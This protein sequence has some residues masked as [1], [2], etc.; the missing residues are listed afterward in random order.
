MSPTV[1]VGRSIQLL[2]EDK[3]IEEK[4]RKEKRRY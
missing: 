3:G 2:D 1:F 4:K